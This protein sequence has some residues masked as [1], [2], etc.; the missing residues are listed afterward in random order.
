MLP[1]RASAVDSTALQPCCAAGTSMSTA[2][3]R[4]RS[5]TR[6]MYWYETENTRQP[7]WQP[8]LSRKH[9]E[10]EQ[11]RQCYHQFRSGIVVH[12]KPIHE[13]PKLLFHAAVRAVLPCPWLSC[14]CLCPLTAGWMMCV[15]TS[16]I[17]WANVG[18]IP[19]RV[20]LASLYESLLF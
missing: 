17:F 12:V 10:E 18:D 5:S 1:A 3:G 2:C 15:Y 20:G 14:S 8:V 7:A 6:F 13:K 11:G 9:V 19:V 16:Q 4:R